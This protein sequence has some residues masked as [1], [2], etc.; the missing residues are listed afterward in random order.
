MPDDIT[1][2]GS[3]AATA[4]QQAQMSANTN[5]SNYSLHLELNSLNSTAVHTPDCCIEKI[6]EESSKQHFEGESCKTSEMTPEDGLDQEYYPMTTAIT[7]ELRLEAENLDRHV[8]GDSIGSPPLSACSSAQAEIEYEKLD[9]DSLDLV[10]DLKE[11]EII[12]CPNFS[13]LMTRRRQRD[14]KV[15]STFEPLQTH[16]NPEVD[17]NLNNELP[18]DCLNPFVNSVLLPEG[19]SSLVNLTNSNSLPE[20][21]VPISTDIEQ[22]ELNI[23]NAVEVATNATD[24]IAFIKSGNDG[25][26]STMHLNGGGISNSALPTPPLLPPPSTFG[27]GNPF[28]M[29][30]CLTLLLQHRNTIMKSGMDY[31]EIAMHFDKMVRK[32]DV[33]RVLNQARR[34]YIDY[35]KIQNAYKQQVQNLK[36]NSS[37]DINK[38]KQSAHPDSDR[39]N[40][41]AQQS[42]TAMNS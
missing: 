20:V 24:D 6:P 32:H 19:D 5:T 42:Q 22:H 23:P 33:T 34:M 21:I 40:P 7:R 16:F 35:L 25:A 11:N 31:N 29:F 26:C 27:G 36:N 8:F 17:S 37:N 9:K 13:E 15:K 12:T 14:N 30:L 41:K 3:T 38:N 18:L 10:D 28:L 4:I 39:A 2:S 1:W